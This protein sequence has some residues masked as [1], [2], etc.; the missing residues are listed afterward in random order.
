MMNAVKAAHEG[1]VNGGWLV[2]SMTA[3]LR[4]N[5]LNDEAVTAIKECA[6]NCK[7]YNKIK[8]AA[9]GDL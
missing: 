2:Q 9:Q 3:Y 5:G 6:L 8:D 4:V 1:L 7:K